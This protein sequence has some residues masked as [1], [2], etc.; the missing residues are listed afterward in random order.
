MI[1]T[2]I[3]PNQQTKTYTAQNVRDAGRH[4]A[5]VLHLNTGMS[6]AEATKHGMTLEKFGIATTNG[7]TFVINKESVQ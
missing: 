6:K 7:Y 4:V 1:V 5:D 3:T 2:R